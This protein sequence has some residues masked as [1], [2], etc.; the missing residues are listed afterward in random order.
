MDFSAI[1]QLRNKRFWWMDVIFYFVM[2]LLIA[3]VL[4][5]LIFLVKNAVQRNDIK[6][7]EV[8]LEN[9]GT[10]DQK[11]Q[12]TEVLKY[13]QKVSNFTTLFENHQFAS[14]VFAFMQTETMPN[15]W[16]RQFILDKKGAV[17]Q[18][19]GESD[20]LDALSRQVAVFEKNDY[21]KNVS[22]INTSLGTGTRE[23][24][25]FSLSLDPKIFNFI[26]DLASVLQTAPETNQAL[27]IQP[28]VATKESEKLIT[29]FHLL[30][31]P[32]VIGTID[33]TNFTIRLDVPAGTD[34]T[35]LT[36]A[37]VI[38]P[39]ASVMP[40]SGAAQDF[41]NP[42]FYTVTAQDGSL[43]AYQVTV[44]V[45][46]QE[47]VQTEQNNSK[48]GILTL[49]VSLMVLVVVVAVGLIIF[50]AWKKKQPKQNII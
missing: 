23:Q 4:C 35:N 12:E 45:L 37:F 48:N 21:V 22:A 18:L 47:V 25:N 43:Q 17:V 39:D 2:S 20:D 6:N 40:V 30:L 27:A 7:E 19:S 16:F 42:V 26:S 41:T 8:K 36:P 14:N 5:Y 50:I 10:E 32:E 46:P 28:A 13:Q 33:Q 9:V 31:T 34:V 49:I 11:V 38:S 29:S 24:F 1:F 15:I 44:N 3:T